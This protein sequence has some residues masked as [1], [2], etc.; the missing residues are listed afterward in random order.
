MCVLLIYIHILANV[1][2]DIY[3][4]SFRAFPNGSKIVKVVIY[5]VYS[6]EAAYTATLAYDLTR[7]MLYPTRD[8]ARL[9]T[10]LVPVF[11]VLGTYYA[12]IYE[13]HT[14]LTYQKWRR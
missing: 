9:T 12:A 6:I 5:V 14:R 11:G 3:Y 10:L 7:L 2:A 13:S 4:V 8:S 1:S